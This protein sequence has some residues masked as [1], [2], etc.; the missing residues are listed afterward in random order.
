MNEVM[1]DEEE[2]SREN[3]IIFINLSPFASARPR[4]VALRLFVPRKSRQSPPKTTGGTVLARATNVDHTAEQKASLCGC[5]LFL[6]RERETM[7]KRLMKVSMHRCV[8]YSMHYAETQTKERRNGRPI[9]SQKPDAMP[10][11]GKRASRAGGSPR[12]SSAGRRRGWRRGVADG[13]GLRFSRSVGR[14][15]AFLP[16]QSKI[17]GRSWRVSHGRQ[18][19]PRFLFC[20]REGPLGGW[21]VRL[22]SGAGTKKRPGRFF[23]G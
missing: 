3:R 5:L 2:R 13:R 16:Q 22:S 20:L 15:L 23:P 7:A 21:S 14:A 9:R 11:L 10:V 18:D 1:D 6:E 4:A 12:R 19:D 8:F 17:P